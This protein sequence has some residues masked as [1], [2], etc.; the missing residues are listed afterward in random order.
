L[1]GD[2]SESG[3]LGQV[4]GDALLGPGAAESEEAE[5]GPPEGGGA[6]RAGGGNLR[7]LQ[8]ALG[9]ASPTT[10][11]RYDRDRRT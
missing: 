6:G 9:H 8:D 2:A 3:Q 5:R 4:D 11:R 10:T 1:P 7:D